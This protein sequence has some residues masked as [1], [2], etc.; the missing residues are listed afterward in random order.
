MA[1]SSDVL[2]TTTYEL[3]GNFN[4]TFSKWHPTFDALYKKG[5]KKTLQGN[6]LEFGLTPDGPGTLNPIITGSEILV[7]ARKMNSVKGHEFAGTTIYV[8][9]VPG[10]DLR[11]ANGK[12]DLI[13]LIKKYPESGLSEFQESVARQLVAGDVPL[14]NNFPTLNGDAT[15]DPAGTGARQGIFE[16][17]AKAAQTTTVHG[18]AKNSITGWHNQY[19]EITSFRT[20]GKMR[21]RQMKRTIEQ[22]GSQRKGADQIYA[23][24]GTYD[25]YLEILDDQVRITA[26]NTRGGD[27]APQNVREGVLV[28]GAEMYADQYITAAA[29]STA[30]AVD[31][32]AYFLNNESWNLFMQ[33]HNAGKETKGDFAH[34]EVG[35]LPNQEMWRYEIVLAWGLF[36]DDLRRNGVVCGGRRA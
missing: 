11:E 20:N 16:F 22:E 23:D 12:E 33:G 19:E 24:N 6:Y 27:R 14:C 34:R 36:C 25:Q 13:G 10:K 5:S 18:V 4:E 2:V 3:W 9:D 15:Y 32:V 31:G 21:M 26:S 35:R 28:L 30:S 7:G 17:A 8:Y 1:F 29:F